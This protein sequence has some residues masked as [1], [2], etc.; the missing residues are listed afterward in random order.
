MLQPV[1]RKIDRIRSKLS[2]MDSE[3]ANQSRSELIQQ[4][5]AAIA[6]YDTAFERFIELNSEG[7][8]AKLNM[9][10]EAQ[11]AIGSAEAG[12][13]DQ[14]NQMLAISENTKLNTLLLPVVAIIIGVSLC[15]ADY[16]QYCSPLRRAAQA[17]SDVAEGKLAI[18]I[19]PGR[20]RRTGHCT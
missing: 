12:R 19:P 9:I 6:A 10:E 8:T 14:K 20:P 17:A 18:D 15:L 2:Q 16:R 3:I 1:G 4:A 7:E 13:A 5:M 11:E